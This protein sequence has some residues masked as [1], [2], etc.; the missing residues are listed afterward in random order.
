MLWRSPV[1]LNADRWTK[2]QS[3]KRS[4]KYLWLDIKNNL[5]N[6]LGGCIRISEVQKEK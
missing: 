4:M 1:V 5:G 6:L 2:K 3:C